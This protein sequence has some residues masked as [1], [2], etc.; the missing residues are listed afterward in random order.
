[1]AEIP[2]RGEPSRWLVIHS[3]LFPGAISQFWVLGW[4]WAWP[5]QGA[6]EGQSPFH[7]HGDKSGKTGDFRCT[8]GPRTLVKSRCCV[9][10]ETM[11]GQPLSQI[12]EETRPH[13]EASQSKTVSP[14]PPCPAPGQSRPAGRLRHLPLL[15][16]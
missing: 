10:Q 8:L 2:E 1:M 12:S 3:R 14:T 11:A 6:A 7:S 5:R 15:L 16:P 13:T 9:W 4:D